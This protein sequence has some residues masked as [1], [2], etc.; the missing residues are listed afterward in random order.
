MRDAI[1]ADIGA[2]VN[3]MDEQLLR[4]IQESG[5]DLSVTE[6]KPPRRFVMAAADTPSGEKAEIVCHKT[7]LLDTELHVGMDRP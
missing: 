4:R 5:A 3:L 6:I 2:D 7:A 1:C